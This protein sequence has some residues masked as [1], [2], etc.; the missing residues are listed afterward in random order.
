MIEQRIPI[1]TPDRAGLV[2]PDGQTV[3]ID[4]NGVLSVVPLT[5]EFKDFFEQVPP[6]GWSV[7][8]GSILTQA[9]TKYPKL[10]E[11]LTTEKNLWKCKSQAEWEALSNTAGGIGGVPFFVVDS[12][13]KTIKLPDT[14]TDHSFG[15]ATEHIGTWEGDAMR[16]ITGS[17]GGFFNFGATSGPFGVANRTD[18]MQAIQSPPGFHDFTFDASKVVPTASQFRPR[19][20][21]L[22]PCVY[23]GGK[24]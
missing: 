4:A 8:D 2:Q 1:A 20:F 12:A 9:D 13:A 7:R 16:N 3:Y 23:V 14:R 21:A 10:W 11:H 18:Y 6:Q 24:S 5:A 22:L 19:R 15:L 17:V